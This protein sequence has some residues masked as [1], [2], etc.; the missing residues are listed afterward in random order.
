M[1]ALS[2]GRTIEDVAVEVAI[3]GLSTGAAA[4]WGA[5]CISRAYRR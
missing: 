4:F 1:D 3:S 5:M 2:N